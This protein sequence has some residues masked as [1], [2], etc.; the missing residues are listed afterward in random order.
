MKLVCWLRGHSWG[1][2]VSQE[3]GVVCRR[4][5]KNQPIA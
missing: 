2:L 3:I 4:C 5:H 1:P